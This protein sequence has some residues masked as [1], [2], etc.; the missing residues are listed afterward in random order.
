MSFQDELAKRQRKR[1]SCG[2]HSWHARTCSSLCNML[3]M[4]THD[5]AC[6]DMMAGERQLICIH[7]GYIVM[8]LSIRLCLHAEKEQHLAGVVKSC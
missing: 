3:S 4:V 2:W 5:N 1:Q 8:R 6:R 7:M